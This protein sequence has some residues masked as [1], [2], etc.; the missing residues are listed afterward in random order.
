MGKAIENKKLIETLKG[1]KAKDGT[2]LI[3]FGSRKTPYGY[4]NLAEHPEI[5]KSAYYDLQNY[6]VHPDVFPSLKLWLD[7]YEPQGL[8]AALRTLNFAIKRNNVGMSLFHA[9]SLFE[10]YIG[11]GGKFS[12]VAGILGRMVT[13]KFWRDLDK[14]PVNARNA[15]E[16][17]I[18]KYYENGHGDIIELALRHGLVVTTPVE[19]Q[20]GRTEFKSIIHSIQDVM[21]K[22]HPI[23]GK[24]VGVYAKIEDKLHSLTWN[25]LHIGMKLETFSRVMESKMTKRAADLE[26]GKSV[27]TV[28]DMAKDVASFVNASFGGINW[29]RSADAV[30]NKVMRGFAQQM[31]GGRGRLMLQLMFFAPDWKISTAQAWYKAIPELK[32]TK[33]NNTELN[34]L[35]QNYLIRSTMIAMVIGNAINYKMSGHFMWQN[36]SHKKNPDRMDKMHAATLVDLGDGRTMNPFKHYAEGLHWMT[37]PGQQ[38]LNALGYLPKEVLTQLTNK[39]Y[40]SSGWAPSIAPAGQVGLGERAA[41]VVGGTMPISAQQLKDVGPGAALSGFLGVPVYGMTAE[42]KAEA[43]QARQEAKRRSND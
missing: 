6:A 36:E 15:L 17:A 8:M 21:E 1:Y 38:M 24:P 43:K 39:K 4:I 23:I 37:S 29:E 42:Q 5:G 32:G 40:L 33:I 30:K 34:K 26:A 13:P 16:T 22:I 14:M 3:V 25:Y 10:A 28:E 9:H 7:S 12:T 2:P 27:Q 11:T 35:H 19:D 18:M 20:L 31:S 41:H